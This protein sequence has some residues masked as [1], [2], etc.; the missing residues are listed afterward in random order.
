MNKPLIIFVIVF[1]IVAGMSNCTK[2][3]TSIPSV[4]QVVNVYPGSPGQDIYLNSSLIKT[5][6]VYGIDTDFFSI[7]AGNYNIKIA[8]TNTTNFT[9]N[10][11]ID[12][13][14]S[15]NYIMFLV[16]EGG[17]IKPEVV[18]NNYSPLGFDT[19]EIRILL[20]SP[21]SPPFDIW[22]RDT[23]A[24]DT[25]QPIYYTRYFNDQYANRTYSSYL[26]LPSGPYNLKFRA[27]GT[28]TTLDSISV[29][30]NPGISYTIYTRGYFD[31]S[32]NIPAFTID[33]LIHN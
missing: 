24:T 17:T 26:V 9:I 14:T 27:T 31:S 11:N 23:V 3:T 21:N 2:T 15:K 6:I 29:T 28:T 8:P 30:L 19:S 4:L 33:T 20:F 18:Q 13:S 12:F 22:V 25:T 32:R 1:F 7:P 10:N 5:P 16:N